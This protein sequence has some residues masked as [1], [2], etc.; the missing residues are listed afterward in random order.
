MTWEMCLTSQTLLREIE[1]RR[2]KRKDIGMTY[3]LA[4]RSSEPTDW[5]AVNAA[6]IARWSMAGLI[7]IKEFAHRWKP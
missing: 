2:L 1:D 3:A 6:I 7:Y 4:M 5:A